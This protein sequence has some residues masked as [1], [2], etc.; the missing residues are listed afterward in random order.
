MGHSCWYLDLTAPAGHS[1]FDPRSQSEHHVPESRFRLVPCVPLAGCDL[2]CVFERIALPPLVCHHWQAVDSP[3][4]A[5]EFG[6]LVIHHYYRSPIA[7]FHPSWVAG[8]LRRQRPWWL[9]QTRFESVG[10]IASSGWVRFDRRVGFRPQ[11]LGCGEWIWRV[12]TLPVPDRWVRAP[13]WWCDTLWS[14]CRP[15][16]NVPCP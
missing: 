15:W 4:S 6:L 8:E 12:K 9:C 2:D 16:A 13:D 11:G 7:A 3:R 14:V 10:R 1:V 5:V